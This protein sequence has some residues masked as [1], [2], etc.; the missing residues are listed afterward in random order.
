MTLSVYKTI[1]LVS[2][3]TQKLAASLSRK[4]RI[5][6]ARSNMEGSSMSKVRQNQQMGMTLILMILSLG[7]KQLLQTSSH[8]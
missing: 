1:P 5:N 8:P 4:C 7:M 3:M 6:Q 2:H